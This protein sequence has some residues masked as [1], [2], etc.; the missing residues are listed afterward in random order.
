MEYS[1][2]GE[3]GPP[4]EGQIRAK[5]QIAESDQKPASEE[6]RGEKTQRQTERLGQRVI[7]TGSRLQNREKHPTKKK[8]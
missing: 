5:V 1:L 2:P 6:S 4:R 8:N 3:V 7:F